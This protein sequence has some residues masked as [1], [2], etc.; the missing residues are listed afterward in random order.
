M[1]S[2]KIRPT[3]QLLAMVKGLSEVPDEVKQTILSQT[4]FYRF[5]Y[6]NPAKQSEYLLSP[7]IFCVVEG[8]VLLSF[9]HENGKKII[10]EV[11]TSGAFFGNIISVHDSM[12][13]EANFYIETLPK[14]SSILIELDEQFF[15][16]LLTT[17]TPFMLAVI[18]S[19]QER[20]FHLEKKVKQTSLDST[21]EKIISQLV[22]VGSIEK[23]GT[24]DIIHIDGKITHEKIAE[25]LG[26]TRETVSKE[27][28]K[29]KKSG[30]MLQVKSNEIV[31]DKKKAESLVK[32]L[33]EK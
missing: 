2:E 28:I 25:T 31:V 20:I 17:C 18:K 19:M 30:L 29:M 11:L 7:K 26:T 4:Q 27:I 22:E 13:Q 16:H 24:V 21:N 8:T 9:L 32:E 14:S 15:L 23:N 33:K 12:Q 10:T 5:S 3:Y 6:T 1:K